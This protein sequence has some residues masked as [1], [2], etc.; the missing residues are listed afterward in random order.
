MT[1]RTT[2]INIS[3]REW[4]VGVPLGNDYR[5]VLVEELKKLRGDDG[6]ALPRGA[7]SNC[8]QKFK[9]ARSTVL[10]V[11]QRYCDTGSVSPRRRSTYRPTLLTDDDYRYRYIELLKTEHPSM[12]YEDIRQKLEEN[13]NVHVS[14][15]T[16]CR[17][18]RSGLRQ[19]KWTWKKMIKPAAERFTERNLI[20]TEA[21]LQA[22]RE[23]DPMRIRF[24]DE[25]GFTLHA[26]QRNYG[27]A[28][29]GLPAV[30]IQRYNSGANFT[31]N[32]LISPFGVSHANIVRGASNT[33]SYLQFFNEA[34]NTVM[35]NG[36]PALL[37]GNVVVVDNCP[38]HHH[39]G[40]AILSESLDNQ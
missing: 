29:I 4:I 37:H 20:Y 19:T 23:I 11:W 30:E 31:L 33:D 35:E 39:R 24:F 2:K 40:G 14:N 27:H 34:A 3:G 6:N 7:V 21:Y 15:S 28:Q 5:S 38:T 16:L 17:A 1:Q 32:L 10:A 36:M 8:A 18:V 26:S 9:V 12:S 22:F 13:A 25:S